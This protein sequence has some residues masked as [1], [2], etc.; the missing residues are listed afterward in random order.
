MALKL[1]NEVYWL[2]VQIN[3]KRIRESLKTGDKA[4]A[5]QAHDM[6]VGE[7]W[8]VGVLKERPKCNRCSFLFLPIFL[9]NF[10]SQLLNNHI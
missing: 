8:R 5:K 3:G 10:S 9:F 7:L 1:R 4:A 6:R 2:D